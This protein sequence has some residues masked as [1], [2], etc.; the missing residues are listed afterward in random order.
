STG[1]AYAFGFQVDLLNPPPGQ[2]TPFSGIFVLQSGGNLVLA[3]GPSPGPNPFPAAVGILISGSGQV[4]TATQ[5]NEGVQRDPLPAN[6]QSCPRP[7]PNVVIGCVKAAVSGP[8]VP[9]SS[10]VGAEL[11]ITAS[12]PEANGATLSRTATVLP[13]PLVGV[14]LTVDCALTSLCTG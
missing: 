1:P 2:I 14:S 10:Q 7:V 6:P 8:A 13:Q 3:V 5:G 11:S 12:E 9:P 4:W